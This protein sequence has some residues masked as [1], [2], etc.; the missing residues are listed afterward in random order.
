MKLI[1]LDKD[2]KELDKID[3]LDLENCEFKKVDGKQDIDN[4][5]KILLNK[6]DYN[7]GVC[8]PNENYDN[9][10]ISFLNNKLLDIIQLKLDDIKGALVSDIFLAQQKDSLILNRMKEVYTT[11]EPQEFYFRYYDNK[12]LQKQYLVKITKVNDLIYLLVEEKTKNDIGSKILDNLEIIQLLDETAIGYTDSSNSTIWTTEI[13]NILEVNPNEYKDDTSNIIEQFVFEDDIN[14]RKNAIGSLSKDNPDTA[15]ILRVIT[16]K[17]NPKYLETILHQNYDENG[18][19]LETLEIIKDVT[20]QLEYQDDIEETLKEK[21]ILLTEI[22]R[23]VKNNLQIILSLINLN[24]SFEKDS[25]TILNDTENRIY[26]MS[27]LHEQIYGSESLSDVNMKDYVETLVDS[28]FNTYSSD[29]NFKSDVAPLYLDMELSIPLGF[30]IT[31]LVTNSI[32]HA[33]P[34]GKEGNLNITFIKTDNKYTLTVEDDGIGLPDDINI[35]EP[36][37]IGLIIVENL[38]LQLNGTLSIEEST[39]TKFKIELEEE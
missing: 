1:I 13:N 12:T 21:E 2:K 25:D 36:S 15:F 23:R 7:V 24:K 31:E 4:D 30:I 28:L 32:K 39:G 14:L 19:L 5:I 37:T 10:Y 17:D 34:D 8:L 22:H 33:Y 29:I 6:M 38:A 35:D 26:A 3:S 27:L 11:G 9:F 16:G 18:N 20:S